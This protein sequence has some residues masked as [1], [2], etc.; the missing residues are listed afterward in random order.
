MN[1]DVKRYYIGVRMLAQPFQCSKRFPFE[2]RVSC[3]RIGIA[4]TILMS[5]F[6]NKALAL[7]SVELRDLQSF[8][9]LV[10]Y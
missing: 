3:T 1:I 4:N 9:G 7:N 10:S 2:C 6:S 5:V 8:L